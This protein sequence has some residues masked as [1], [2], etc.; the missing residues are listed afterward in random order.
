MGCQ[1]PI[2]TSM[3]MYIVQHVCV[4]QKK[5]QQHSYIYFFSAP[6]IE[7]DTLAHQP[8]KTTNGGGR[9]SPITKSDRVKVTLCWISVSENRFPA[10]ACSSLLC[11]VN[12][13]YIKRL[14]NVIENDEIRVSPRDDLM[15][16]FRDPCCSHDSLCS[17]QKYFLLHKGIE[18]EFNPSALFAHSELFNVHKIKRRDD[19]SFVVAFIKMMFLPLLFF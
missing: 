17:T 2:D 14:V 19:E 10:Y 7:I 4:I 12:L 6:Y 13:K 16:N 1:F 3:L 11:L 8:A 15:F 9:T 5:T 18:P